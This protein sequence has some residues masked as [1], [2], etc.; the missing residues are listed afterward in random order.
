MGDTTMKGDPFGEIRSGQVDE[1]ASP[2]QVSDFHKNADTD[3]SVTSTH[4]TLGSRRGQATPGDH[5]H[6]GKNSRRIGDG[7]G[8]TVTGSRGTGAAITSLIAA[9]VTAGIDL[10]DNTV[11]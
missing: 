7:L 9:L 1:T 8:L 6:D 3:A 2:K 5:V 10:T 4:H 11:A